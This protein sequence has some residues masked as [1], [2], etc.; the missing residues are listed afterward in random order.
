MSENNDISKAETAAP[1]KIFKTLK[2]QRESRGLSLQDIFSTT[3]ISVINL[4]SLED[5]D[6]KSLPPPIY[7]KSFISKYTLAIGSDEKPLLG[8]YESYLATASRPAKI[9]EVRK[10]W[11]EENRRYWILYGSL[12]ISIAI[13]LIV[14]T[15]FLYNHKGKT[16]PPASQPVQ[17]R[18]APSVA[19]KPET[20]ATVSQTKTAKDTTPQEIVQPSSGQGMKNTYLLMI[21]A[22]E[23]TWI[24]IVKDKKET[25]EILLRP[26][27]KIEREASD[28]FLLDIGNAGGINIQFQGK[29]LGELGKHGEVIHIRLP[30]QEHAENNR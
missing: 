4:T 24:R 13:G 10:P 19:N 25:S 21:E 16:D 9:A 6:F 3:R 28:S 18:A 29:S 23:L 15:L 5:G 14:L 27:E 7:T 26:G 2:K 8:A 20:L 17:E 12:S 22:R 11:P 1:E 30:K